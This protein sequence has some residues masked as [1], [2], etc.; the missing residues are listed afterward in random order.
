MN[1]FA[2]LILTNGRPNNVKT[3]KTLRR[4][5]Y[6]GKCYLVVDDLDKTK[7]EY[8]KKYGD[9]V[10]VFDKKDIAKR[11]DDFGY[12]KDKMG[13]IFYARNASFEIARKLG[14]KYFMQ[15]DDDYVGF[16][17]RVDENFKWK[18]RAVKDLDKAFGIMLDF[19]KKT[20]ALTLAMAQAGD[21]IGGIQG[22]YGKKIQL[23]RKAMNSFICDVDNPIK[24][25]GK[26]NEDVN[27]YTSE[28]M[29]GKLFLTHNCF[30]LVQTMTQQNKGGM[31]G[32]YLDGGTYIK[33][34]YSVIANPSSVKIGIMQAKNT[35]IHHKVYW[36]NTAPK[37]IRETNK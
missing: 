22:S 26:I 29:R 8:I 28:G 31:T 24:F 30:S 19:Y 34:F 15:F 9:I 2:I 36:N 20:G 16:D 18:T 10:K 7:D 5:G 25:V 3:L 13:S 4:K 37:I 17:Y 14:L 1:N 11:F 32:I 27:T 21:Y 33:S 35:R 23:T 6:K 12:E